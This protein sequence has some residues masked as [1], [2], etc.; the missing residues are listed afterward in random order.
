MVISTYG[1]NV[2]SVRILNQP[3]RVL[4]WKSMF[5]PLRPQHLLVGGWLILLVMAYVQFATAYH[6]IILFICWLVL[7]FWMLISRLKLYLC[8]LWYQYCLCWSCLG[9]NLWWGA[10]WGDTQNMNET[11]SET[12]YDN[13]CHTLAICW[14]SLWWL[15]CSLCSQTIIWIWM[16]ERPRMMEIPRKVQW[17]TLEVMK[18]SLSC[19]LSQERN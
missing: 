16:K 3:L 4:V 1:R 6:T 8:R 11:K 7:G 2:W 17:S 15:G 9:L 19:F 18:I 10:V 13:G 14:H 5:C 12:F